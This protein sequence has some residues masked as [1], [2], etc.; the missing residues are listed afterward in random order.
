MKIKI[1]LLF[2]FI[3][4]AL[5]VKSIFSQQLDGGAF[6]APVAKFGSIAGQSAIF[7]GGRF[8]WVIDSSIVLGGGIYALTS[9]VKTNITDP[10]SGQN[11]MLGFN[12]GGVELEYIFFARSNVHFSVDM[13]FAGAGTTYSVINK[14]VSHSNYFSQNLLLWEPQLNI[15]FNVLYWFHIDTGVSFRICTS[16]G[17][18]TFYHTGGISLKDLSGAS[19]LVTFKFG[20]F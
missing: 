12:C 14:D 3:C 10:I 4:T 1:F 7:A 18:E 5:M 13:L 17:T 2:S 9:R 11:V 19:G 15:E 8:G 6:G 20:S 16:P